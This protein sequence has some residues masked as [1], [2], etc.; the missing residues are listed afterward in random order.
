MITF[1]KKVLLISFLSIS[2][3]F[4]LELFPTWNNSLKGTADFNP[5]IIGSGLNYTRNSEGHDS[6]SPSLSW[7]MR[8]QISRMFSIKSNLEASFMK[9]QNEKSSFISSSADL[10]F[11]IRTSRDFEISLKSGAHFSKDSQSS[12]SYGVEIEHNSG[13]LRK[14]NIDSVYLGFERVPNLRSSVRRVISGVRFN[15]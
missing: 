3:T 15:L 9:D 5:L 13:F 2:S 4:S 12:I 1:M 11:G 10:F 6:L 7:M 14:W 8:Y